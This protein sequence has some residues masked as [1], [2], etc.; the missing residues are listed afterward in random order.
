MSA[1]AQLLA[2]MR[3]ELVELEL[4]VRLGGSFPSAIFLLQVDIK[5]C[6]DQLIQDM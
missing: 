3:L 6:A 2:F 4:V 1:G 5:R